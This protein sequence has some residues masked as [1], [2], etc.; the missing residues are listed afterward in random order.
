MKL[1][2]GGYPELIHVNTELMKESIL[3]VAMTENGYILKSQ[4]IR[5]KQ[6]LSDELKI[7]KGNPILKIKVPK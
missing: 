3:L 6:G 5:S 4:L 2:K 7:F 1:S